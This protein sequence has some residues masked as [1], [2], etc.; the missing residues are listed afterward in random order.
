M[1]GLFLKKVHFTDFTGCFMETKA[2]YFARLEAAG[3]FKARKPNIN[4]CR[5]V[6][7]M[8]LNAP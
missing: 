4:G 2:F 8:G 7:A 1:P 3:P 5:A 6:S